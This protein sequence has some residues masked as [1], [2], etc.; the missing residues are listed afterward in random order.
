MNLSKIAAIGLAAL[1]VTA[2]AAAAMPGNAPDHAGADDEQ[3]S[4]RRPDDAEDDENATDD[5]GAPPATVADA[6]GADAARGPPADLPTQAPDH[7]SR[8][9]DLI[10]EFLS[11][12]LDGSLGDAVSDASPDGP[13]TPANASG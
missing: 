7:V 1:L 6:G 11:G 5:A 3:T 2:G 12:D 9:H 8:I 4:D 13:E 10:R